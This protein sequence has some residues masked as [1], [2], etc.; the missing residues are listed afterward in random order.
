ME[1]RIERRSVIHQ[2]M[3]LVEILAKAIRIF[4]LQEGFLWEVQVWVELPL[5][6][7]TREHSGAWVE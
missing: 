5:H 4:R 3:A 2:V 6:I 1:K 7:S